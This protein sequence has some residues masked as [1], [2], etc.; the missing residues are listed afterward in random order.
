[1][2]LLE[3]A[4]KANAAYI[5]QAARE[6]CKVCLAALPQ[7]GGFSSHGVE[8]VKCAECQ[9]LNGRYQDGETFWSQMYTGASR[10]YSELY[11]GSD[12][13]ERVREIYSPKLDFLLEVI[14]GGELDSILDIGCGAGFFV[15]AALER[16]VDA[17]GIDVNQAMIV[18]GNDKI[19]QLRGKRPLE[20]VSGSDFSHRIERSRAQVLSAIGVIEHLSD[21]QEFYRAFRASDFQYLS[22]SFPMFSLSAAIEHAFPSVAP[23]HLQGEHTHLFSEESLHRIYEILNVEPVAEWRFG[24]DFMDL[25]RSL[26]SSATESG[27]SDLVDDLSLRMAPCIDD[28]Q[29]VLDRA[30]YCSEIHVLARR[31]NP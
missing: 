6:E 7:D 17:E 22:F 30:H 3:K 2:S 29:A 21:L 25:F 31:I 12:F 1:M 23:R 4:L 10:D 19:G 9:H 26:I 11:L 16:G 18:A 28:L 24:T 14:P 20:L 8:Y 5:S 27:G 13:E 15:E